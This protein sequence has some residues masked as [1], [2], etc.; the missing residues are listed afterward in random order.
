MPGWSLRVLV[1]VA[2]P[3][4]EQSLWS[5]R[6]RFWL[7]SPGWQ[8][9]TQRWSRSRT[10]IV[11]RQVLKEGKGFR[12]WDQKRRNG[13]RAGDRRQEDTAPAMQKATSLLLSRLGRACPHST[14]KGICTFKYVLLSVP[15]LYQN[16]VAIILK[17][18]CEWNCI[19]GRDTGNLVFSFLVFTT[20]G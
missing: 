6:W 20:A 9:Q 13:C 18:T 12:D 16:H 2:M 10:S 5:I 19:I 17:N 8:V 1:W 15:I 4:P 14:P 7:T 3:I 11:W